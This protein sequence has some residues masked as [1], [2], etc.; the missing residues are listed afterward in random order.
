MSQTV[1]TKRKMDPEEKKFWATYMGMLRAIDT[2]IA[3]RKKRY[4]SSPGPHLN[5][6]E[7][8]IVQGEAAN[9][10]W[11]YLVARAPEHGID[12][13]RPLVPATVLDLA[14]VEAGPKLAAVKGCHL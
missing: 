7:W 14:L 8:R 13:V 1:L 5:A 2:E 11:N 9:Y 3:A 12:F 4:A 6:I 10:I